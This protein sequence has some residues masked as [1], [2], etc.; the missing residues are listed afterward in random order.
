MECRDLKEL[1]SASIDGEAPPAEARRIGEHLEKCA[2][3]RALERK[4]RAT[5]IGVARTEGAVPPD[6]RERLFARMEAEDLLPRRRSLFAYSLRWA[7]VPL[8]AA[9]ALAFFLL[10]SPEKGKDAILP[11]GQDPRVAQ[12]TPVTEPPAPMTVAQPAPA[13]PG[14]SAQTAKDPQDAAGREPAPAAAA[15]RI[16]SEL[17]PEEQEIIAH[18]DV[19]EDPAALDAPG[20][21]DEMEIFTPSGRRQG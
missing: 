2:E 6:F 1:L 21:I 7:A 5:G 15:A 19:L 17:T 4:M 16:G 9:A 3:C 12:R 18:L 14:A 8:A 11:Q 13:S 10:A 20:D